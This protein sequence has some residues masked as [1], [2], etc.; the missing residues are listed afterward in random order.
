MAQQAAGYYTQF[1]IKRIE[2]L[3]CA[4]KEHQDKI[5][6]Y[7]GNNEYVVLYWEGEIERL[8]EKIKEEKRKLEEG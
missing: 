5:E 1:E 4:R 8:D 3:K 6:N 7:D 2:G